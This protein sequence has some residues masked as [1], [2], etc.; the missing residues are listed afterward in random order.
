MLKK[1]GTMVRSGYKNSIRSEEQ[2]FGLTTTDPEMM[3]IIKEHS[4]VFRSNLP[5]G[6]PLQRTVDNEIETN[7]EAKLPSCRLFRLSQKN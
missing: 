4:D 2:E 7:P 1:R 5:Y 6:L 3:K